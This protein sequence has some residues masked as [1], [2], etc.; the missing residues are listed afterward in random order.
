MWH[1]W[2]MC[3][4]YMPNRMIPTVL[5]CA[6]TRAR[7]NSSAKCASRNE[8]RLVVLYDIH[9]GWRHVDV[10]GQRT[11]YDFAHQMKALVDEHYG[12]AERIRIV[13]DNLSTHTAAALYD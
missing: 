13:L 2:K 1:G 4:T 8:Q 5:W 7:R 11:S 10:T 6:L 3:W 9:A 12:Q